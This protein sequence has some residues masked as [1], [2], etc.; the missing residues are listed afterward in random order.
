VRVEGRHTFA[1]E[2]AEIWSAL[3]DPATLAATLP[4]VKRLEVTGPD[5]YELSASVGVGSVKGLF[6]GTFA[7]ED[8]TDLESCVLHGSARGA[9]GS[10]TVEAQVRLSDADGGS[11]QLDY[12]ADASVTGPIAGVGQRMIAS[13]SKK[14]ARQFFEAVDAY[15]PQELAPAEGASDA[16]RRTV[17]ERPAAPA[18]DHQLFL[19]GVLVGFAFALAGV[20]VGRWSV[21]GRR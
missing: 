16:R 6:E 2:R 3:Q 7:V 8:K 19:R 15:E 13:A 1:K 20:L 21:S 12:S 10:A 17:F 5:R 18:S 14:M 4:G 11:T 9:S